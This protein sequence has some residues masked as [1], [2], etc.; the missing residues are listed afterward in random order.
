MFYIYNKKFI[1]IYIIIV[2][3]FEQNENIFLKIR[4][5]LFIFINDEQMII[6]L[7]KNFVAIDL[8]KIE[9]KLFVN[10]KRNIFRNKFFLIKL[11]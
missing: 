6:L 4:I 3:R 7:N 8:N 2:E 10:N 1:N 5:S 9:G 11:K